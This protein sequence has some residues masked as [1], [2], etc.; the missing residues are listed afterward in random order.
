[1]Q[2]IDFDE[3]DRAVNSV[4]NRTPEAEATAAPASVPEPT[5]TPDVVAQPVVPAPSLAARRS[6][7]RFMD[8]V[9]PS[10]D[11]RPQTS[12]A[13]SLPRQEVDRT[14]VAER[15]EP[16]AATGAAFHWPD[17]IDMI[18]EQSLAELPIE[19][20]IEPLVA[21]V[22]EETP[23]LLPAPSIFDEP[24]PLE[25]PFLSD[26]KVEKRPLGAFSTTE[27]ES[28][29][30]L[31][32][33]FPAPTMSQERETTPSD[34]APLISETEAESAADMPRELH[35]D[36]LLLEAH[37]VDEPAPELVTLGA[38]P[39]ATVAETPVGPTSITQ[40]YQEHPSTGSQPS[41]SIYDTEAYHKPLTHP[42]KKHSSIL[43]IIWIIALIVFGGGIGVAINFLVLPTLG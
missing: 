38:T 29:I 10:S 31:L 23:S 18:E 33:D 11:M 12:S 27:A 34:E 30:P 3:I 9:H 37:G 7:G 25:S 40:Q 14:V 2:D 5:P 4:T 13:P 35:E 20:P 39:I 43:I 19:P 22:P 17:P 21:P 8:V 15:Q 1:M 41:G 28:E 24:A 42:V 32:E 16:A 36:V 26:T 6:S